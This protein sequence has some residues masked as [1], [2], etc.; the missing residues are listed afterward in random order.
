V[1]NQKRVSEWLREATVFLV[2][3]GEPTIRAEIIGHL[4]DTFDFT[5]EEREVVRDGEAWIE[6]FLWMS[7]GLVKAGWVVKDGSGVW[8]ATAEAAQALDRYTD[9]GS[10]QRAIDTAYLA[11]R[12]SNRPSQRRA[13][14]IR[15]SSVLGVNLVPEWLRDGY[16]SLAGSQL[17]PI[18]PGVSVA[19][20]AAAATEDYAHL[21]HHELN[22]K[23]D[24]IVAF[25]TR[26]SVGDVV[27]TTSE[28]HIYVGDVTTSC[29]YQPSE[30]GLSNLRRRVDWR[31]ADAPI[32]YSDLPAPLPARLQTGRDVLDLTADLNLIDELTLPAPVATGG[33]EPSPQPR[34]EHLREPSLELAEELLVDR[35]WLS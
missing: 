18:D 22:A 10:F 32:D 25:V 14:L 13:W 20:L 11:W 7:I 17:W 3:R 6:R 31:N 30:G 27:V 35:A 15:G 28:H 16:C 34:H 9:P 24:E 33:D 21:K 2:E 4:S 1:I 26:V 23:V 8:A 12:R 29:E 5:A 19:D